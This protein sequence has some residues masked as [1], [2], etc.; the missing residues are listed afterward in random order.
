MAGKIES[1]DLI[2]KIDANN[3]KKQAWFNHANVR[4]SPDSPGNEALIEAQVLRLME[5]CRLFSQEEETTSATTNI[6]TNDN[7]NDET[8]ADKINNTNR[9]SDNSLALFHRHE[10]KTSWNILGNGAFSEVYSVQKFYLLDEGFVDD[11][12]N[13]AR[14]R[15]R[16]D[17]AG[18]SIIQRQQC[19]Q[20]ESTTQY[21][22]VQQQPKQYVVKH[23]R[24]DLLTDRKKFIHAAGDLV[25][26]A[27]YLSKF[28]HPNIIKLRGCA[29]GGSSAY[30]N[31]KHDGFFLLLD[32]LHST[33]SHK[34]EDWKQ[35]GHQQQIIYSN[36]L[37]DF[38]H[39]LDISHQ[40]ASALEYLHGKD[41]V[42]RD[43]KPDNIGLMNYPGGK[44]TVQLFDFGLCR[45]IPEASPAENKVFHM[46][47]VGTRRYMS[48][49][50]YLGKHYNVKADVYSWS[51]VLHSMITLQRP[52]E[53][54]DSKLHKLLV[55]QEGVR[56]TIYKEWP[57]PIQEL[58]RQGWAAQSCDRPSMKNICSTIA[59]LLEN[60]GYQ[61]LDNTAT[62]TATSSNNIDDNNIH[63]ENEIL[64]LPLPSKQSKEDDSF[65]TSPTV[66]NS[67][68]GFVESWTK[69]LCSGGSNTN[70]EN[71]KRSNMQNMLRTLEAHMVA[72]NAGGRLF[73]IKSHK[74]P[75]YR[76]RL[77]G[78]GMD[79]PHGFHLRSSFL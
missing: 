71:S 1:N 55:C 25:M 23:L 79:K 77:G 74:Q 38:Q 4:H 53:M 20:L 21:N 8:A 22:T 78:G 35:H 6:N 46:S 48:P 17:T 40:I 11:E 12:Q 32:R 42:Y 67:V 57:Q 27:M 31:G 49:E 73:N 69:H 7:D 70:K 51:I 5:E 33:L 54:Y 68:S 15:L 58:L 14:E 28:N 61:C 13:K 3:S 16:K 24:R 30:Q 50:V 26:E 76:D 60:I 36:R 9:S 41:I 34:I 63:D 62:S 72:D 56:P 52:F 66:D 10:I 29:V 43:L 47:G 45:E 64:N 37:I 19:L 59:G 65:C 75:Y 39:K 2:H 44:V 18:T